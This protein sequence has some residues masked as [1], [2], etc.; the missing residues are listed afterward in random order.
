M[1]EAKFER[2]CEIV[3]DL[4]DA[5][6]AAA[7]NVKRQIVEMQGETSTK[8]TE[9]SNAGDA[10]PDLTL[11][12]SKDTIGP[13]GPFRLIE[14]TANLQNVNYQRLI[15]YLRAH[16]GKATINGSFVWLFT[17]GS[18]NVGVKPKA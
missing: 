3:C 14:K 18:G 8:K 6:E 5:V 1:S 12:I 9:R 7:V 16:S 11:F 10:A 4:A 13:H 17:D 15:A 2:L